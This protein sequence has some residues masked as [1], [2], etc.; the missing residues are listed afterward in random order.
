ML[1]NKKMSLMGNIIFLLVYNSIIASEKP[2]A[3]CEGF[4]THQFDFLAKNTVRTP[5]N[6]K[7]QR[8]SWYQVTPYVAEFYCTI[9]NA[10]LLYVA[11]DYLSQQPIVATAL[12]CAAMASAASH[13]APKE[14]LN[15]LDKVVVKATVVARV[16]DC[17]LYNTTALTEVMTDS[18]TFAPALATASLYS[19]DAA[20]AHC[21][22][23]KNYRSK[24][25]TKTHVL[26][27]LFAA[28][29]AYVFF[30]FAC[31]N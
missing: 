20:L 28:Y 30:E 31:N 14:Y 16:Y 29:M 3:R 11:H 26:C 9:S 24:Y 4:W 2:L 21:K 17:N 1:F 22:K 12:M 8:E 6:K 25:Q 19:V 18:T 23:L 5:T 13:A 7:S 15:A 27:H 10:P